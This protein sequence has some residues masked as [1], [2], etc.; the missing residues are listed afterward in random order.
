MTELRAKMIRDM[1]L[2]RLAESTKRNYLNAVIALAKHYK[3]SPDQITDKQVQ[4]YLLYLLNEKKLSWGSCD[5][6]M[7]GLRF[8][9][10]VTLGRESIGFA[11][12]PCKT[13]KKLPEILSTE[14]VERLFNR[15]RLLKHRA[16][17]MTTYGAGLRASEVIH[18]KLTDIDSQRMMIRVEQGKGNKD[19]YTILSQRLLEVLRA[20]W[21]KYRPKL[22]LFPGK[23]RHQPQ[24]TYSGLR[25]V[26]VAAKKQAG[27]Q[28][29]GGMH[30]LRH[31]FA[32]HLLEVG[33]DLRTIQVLL[34]HTSLLTTAL[35]MRVT[36]KKLDS[37]KSPLDLLDI[38]PIETPQIAGPPLTT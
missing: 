28:K 30:M 14:E 29:G 5:L 21:N 24:M 38:P 35:Y 37:T 33:V 31:S 36:R 32:T 26:F 9:Y 3:K 16:V 22:W 4:D 7:S 15:T 23:G 20:Y 2:R 1:E 6:H 34:G 8:L 10:K 19:R 11:I 27:I 18:L 12:P 17:L 13:A 25:K